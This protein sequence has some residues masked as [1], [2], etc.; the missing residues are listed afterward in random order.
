MSQS[1]PPAL[2]LYHSEFCGYC[3]RVRAVI[4]ELGLEVAY[5]STLRDRVAA[6]ELLAARGRRTVPVLRIDH[7]E[8]QQWMGESAD[9]IRYLRML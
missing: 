5:K 7:A 2:T 8:G 9:I 6:S 4:D 1:F 3:Y